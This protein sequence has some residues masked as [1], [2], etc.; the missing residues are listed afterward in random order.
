LNALDALGVYGEKYA[1][2]AA[3][4]LLLKA[5]R[6]T[7]AG[8]WGTYSQ[9]K[10]GGIPSNWVEL[11]PESRIFRNEVP[12]LDEDGNASVAHQ[13]LFV[14]PKLEEAL[15]PILDPNYMNRVPGFQKARA[16]QAWIKT[17]ELGLSV[18]HLKALNLS[19]LGNQGVD[20]IIKSYVTDMDTPEF[21]NAEKA[22]VRA[23]LTTPILNK[24]VEVYKALQPSSLPTTTDKIRSLP[25]IKTLDNIASGVSHLTF[26]IVQRKFKVMDAS[27]KYAAWLAKHPNA[28]AQESFEAQRQI[29]KQVNSVYGGLNWENIGV[30]RTALELSKALLLAP[31]WTFSNVLNLK[32]AGESGAGGNAARL[33]WLKSIMWGLALTAGTSL[34]MSGHVSKD[35]TRVALGRD[36]NGKEL[37][38]NVYFVG[39]PGDLSLLIHNSKR[40]GAVVGLARTIGSKLGPFPRAAINMS[41]N[42]DAAGR[43]I[44]PK[45]TNK[46]LIGQTVPKHQPG[47]LEKTGIGAEEL[48]KEILPVPFSVTSIAQMLMDPKHHYTKAQYAEAALSGRK[49]QEVR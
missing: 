24:T 21:R 7:K 4:H 41:S 37:D 38:D 15:R 44:I 25:G 43:Q 8:K 10:K 2:T 5:I 13:T 34:L 18:F 45:S 36:K 11:S 19:A 39:A 40:Y 47:A 1:T 42:Q 6:K 26:G 48:V 12:F 33:F 20:G 9:Q 29:A 32:Y 3:Y 46:N 23:G 35:P 28:G 16:Y 27:I 17:I 49:P 14:P 31:D 30:Q 22:W